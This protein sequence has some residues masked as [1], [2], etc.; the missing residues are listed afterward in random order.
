MDLPRQVQVGD[1]GRGH[2]DHASAR[3]GQV[4]LT[5]R[6]GQVLRE[7]SA[8]MRRTVSSWELKDRLQQVLRVVGHQTRRVWTGNG[9]THIELR[10]VGAEDI[11][12]LARRVET[13]AQA[14][15]GV[16]WTAFHPATRRLVVSWEPGREDEDALAATVEE[17]EAGQGVLE[18]DFGDEGP[19]HP[20]DVEPALRCVIEIAGDVVGMGIALGLRLSAM[21]P[22]K[23]ATNL[24]AMLSVLDGA[25]QLREVIERTAGRQTT[26]LFLGLTNAVA[27]GLAQGPI[28]PAV[29]MTRQLL[30]AREIAARRKV[31]AERE[32]ELA[33]RPELEVSP[34]EPRDP[35]PTPLPDG[36]IERYSDMAWLVSL[37]GFG[38][39]VAATRNFERSLAPLFAALPKPAG[40]GRRAWATEMVRVLGDHGIVPLDA[41]V[42]RRL[43]RLDTLVVEGELLRDPPLKV[44]EIFPIGPIAVDEASRAAEELF[45][46]KALDKVR[47]KD[48]WELGPLGAL[49]ASIS[50]TTTRRARELGAQG[51][52]V[53]GL[54][55]RGAVVALIEARAPHA[56]EVARLL[57]AARRARLR[58]I[59]ATDTPE[60]FAA[61]PAERFIAGGDALVKGVRRLQRN[62]HGVFLLT[63]GDH[64]ALA[65][66]DCGVGLLHP[67]RPIPWHADLIG[68]PEL[69]DA[70]LIL[71]ACRASRR[72]ARHSVNLALAGASAG[73]MLALGGL[74]KATNRRVMTAVNAAAFVSIANGVRLARGFGRRSRALEAAEIP[75]HALSP[76]AV[77]DRLQSSADG[78]TRGGPSAPRPPAEVT[79]ARPV[80]L[81][82]AVGEE[83]LNPLT[84][85]LAAGAG[86][87]AVVGSAMDAG[88]VAGVMGL[89][90]LV[91][92][93]QRFRAWDAIEALERTGHQRVRVRRD[94]RL[95]ELDARRLLVGDVIELEAGELVPADCRLLEARNLEVDESSLTGESL[96]VSKRVAPSFAP[97][98]A[99][100]SSML[101][102]D[103]SVAAGQAVAVVIATDD[104]VESRRGVDADLRAPESGVEVRLSELTNLTAPVAVLSGMGVVAAGWIRGRPVQEVL[105]AA[106]SLAVAAV[107]EGLP[108]LATVAQLAAA[109]R[110]AARGALVRNHRAIE[111]L[112]R[113]DV[114]CLDKTGTLTL[115]EIHLHSVSDGVRAVAPAELGE[116]AD[117]REVLGIG[118]AACGEESDEAHLEDPIDRALL[119]I[120][121]ELGVTA[122]EGASGWELLDELPF[123]SERG[124]HAV[125]GQCERG[126]ILRVKGAPEAIL[127][128][129]AVWAH[130]DGERILDDATREALAKETRRLA[131][132]GL[133]VLAVAERRL[134]RARKATEE[135][136]QKLTFR[137][138]LAFSDPVRPTASA[139][140][141]E[142]RGAGIELVMITG[143]HPSTA[144]RIAAELG[145]LNG[146]RIVTGPELDAMDDESLTREVEGVSVFARVTPAH[147]V[148][149]VRAFQRAGRLVAMT[150]DGANDASAIR[151][152]H[153]GIALGGRSTAAARGAADL[154]VTD[155]RIETIVAALVEGRAMW[156]SVRDAVALLVGGNL[157]EIAFT[158]LGGLV[159]GRPPL[160]ARQ[161]LLVN[162]LTDV[163]PAMAIALR[164]PEGR[165][166]EE[167]LREG[168]EAS[169][170]KA[171]QHDIALRA[172]ITTAGAGAA[173]LTSRFIGDRRGAST[174]GLLSL[175]GT[176]LGQT[177]VTGHRSRPVILAGVGSAAV[178]AAIVQTP[179][180]SGFFGCRPVGP[181]GWTIAA[182]SAAGATALSLIAPRFVPDLSSWF[183]RLPLQDRFAPPG[184][185]GGPNDDGGDDDDDFA[186]PPSRV[187][188]G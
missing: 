32:P 134:S 4:G 173:W 113:V 91:G 33:G 93:V 164:H 17:V 170:G 185:A 63:S 30:V 140:L 13:A 74:A 129:C 153:V 49:S 44:G 157:G 145:L 90:A 46:P 104:Q 81:A 71:E 67:G 5:D 181:L 97:Q 123:T 12:E 77:L 122:S 150:G 79:T 45:T 98:V 2:R 182:S 84:P 89:N 56:G 52:P 23:R 160:N 115:G 47:S 10:D 161:L 27:Q 165:A 119:H 124:Y 87:S 186:A 156:A 76:E 85:I 176:Q 167:L 187:S 36:P 65:T 188:G 135:R 101:Y 149:I 163:A 120:G 9:R 50:E 130:P 6:F 105:G 55:H 18:A 133:R 152:A 40:L 57:R 169:L 111:A 102:A 141:A 142:L 43:D 8:T 39:G 109:K 16:A 155:G 103:T 21:S 177:L 172:L 42:L 159:D 132:R 80:R 131:R 99:E 69:G 34:T 137:G 162:L 15:P 48:G 154:V 41:T 1:G 175:V 26:E 88:L 166:P 11:M 20:A 180:L 7:T 82:K 114:F 29:H 3:G 70:T 179:G 59:I 68:G 83:L 116:E 117:F 171:L 53:L 127:P 66:A 148:R 112:G 37:G 31:W 125:L 100:R 168:P 25:P 121:E 94:G 178:L 22:N 38:A 61:T 110:L 183:D 96:P 144:E 126:R 107:P 139:A 14:L 60:E 58:L 78:L 128:A 73:S 138:F 62:G 108:V 184:A 54:A 106:V 19:E 136:V 143:D 118:V 72:V 64:P 95:G 35:R 146:H 28:G 86:I 51:I 158:L 92:G 147:K 174:V 75:W 151:L 24:A